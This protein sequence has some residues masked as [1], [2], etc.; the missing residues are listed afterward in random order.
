MYKKTPG[1]VTSRD[2]VTRPGVFFLIVVITAGPT[3]PRRFKA[4]AK[5][6]T[7][8]YALG[9]SKSIINILIITLVFGGSYFWY[10]ARAV[11]SIPLTYRL[12]AVAKDFGL[13]E[14][15][16]LSVISEAESLWENATGL[17]LFTQAD[18]AKLAI[19]FIFDERQQFTNAEEALSDQ[20]E[21]A[22][23]VSKEVEEQYAKLVGEYNDLNQIYETR[24]ANYEH[25]LNSYNQEVERWNQEGGAPQEIYDELNQK[26]DLLDNEQLELN[27][28]REKLKI[29]V[30]EINKL[31][32]RANEIVN[33][34][35]Q[36]VNTYNHT[37]SEGAEFTQG[38]YQGDKINIYQFKTREELI[39]VL[40]HEFGHALGIDHVENAKSIM[41]MQMG[42]Q[43]VSTGLT[44]EDL[45]DFRLVCGDGSTLSKVKFW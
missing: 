28:V 26:K 30:T 39:L 31:T 8:C 44:A 22:R 36:G 18:D 25:S 12:D 29:L 34:Y 38:D 41:Y 17:N 5:K 7:F 10:E 15:E 37:F 6:A 21:Q 20:L 11:C 23:E 3:G 16:A 19:N 27:D 2:D 40:A 24:K 13:T 33:K 4:N 32:E 45:A 14:A 1:A 9:M 43:S 35:N 42:E